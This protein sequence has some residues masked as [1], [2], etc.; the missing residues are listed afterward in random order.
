[1]LVVGTERG[2]RVAYGGEGKHVKLGCV[3]TLDSRGLT[4]AITVEAEKG[5][6]S[7]VVGD[8]YG[9]VRRRTGQI[10]TG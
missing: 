6:F 9:T 1:M 10:R 8:D 3:S 4:S 7:H 5:E 2:G